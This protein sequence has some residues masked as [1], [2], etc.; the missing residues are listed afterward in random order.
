MRRGN[1]LLA[2]AVGA[3]FQSTHPLRGAT[4]GAELLA[5]PGLISIHAPLA[6]CDFVSGGVLTVLGIFQS[7]HPL[8]SAT[9]VAACGFQVHSISIHA[10]LA[11]CDTAVCLV[12]LVKVRNFNPR[13]PCGVRHVLP[14]R[15]DLLIKFQS[16]H[17]LRGATFGYFFQSS[18]YLISIHAPLAGC[19]WE[20]R[21]PPEVFKYF[22]PRTP[23]GVRPPRSECNTAL[24]AISIHAPLAGCDDLLPPHIQPSP[25]ISIHAPLAGCDY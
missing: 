21:Y 18:S 16:T 14:L 5:V 23:C 19:D 3:G 11:G 6:G 12:L 20:E 17:P 24:R 2:H 1:T 4:A 15:G 13:T 25:V 7:T 22:N 10:P 9:L 8:R